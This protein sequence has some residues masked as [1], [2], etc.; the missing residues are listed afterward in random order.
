MKNIK[1]IVF[2]NIKTYEKI[3]LEYIPFDEIL[4]YKNIVYFY[5]YCRAKNIIF[6]TVYDLTTKK[7]LLNI[8]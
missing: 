6:L 3:E 1:L 4:I 8:I 5:N 7:L 2:F